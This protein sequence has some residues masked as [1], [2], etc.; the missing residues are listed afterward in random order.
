MIFLITL[1]WILSII[2]FLV[3]FYKADFNFKDTFIILKRWAFSFKEFVLKEKDK[4]VIEKTRERNIIETKD[5]EEEGDCKHPTGFPL[6]LCLSTE[7]NDDERRIRK[8]VLNKIKKEPVYF[9]DRNM[10][11]SITKKLVVPLETLIFFNKELNPLVNEHGEIILSTREE[12][13]VENI[14]S[15]IME[16]R[17]SNEIIYQTDSEIVNAISELI[18]ISKET[19]ATISE[20]GEKFKEKLI[21]KKEEQNS[22]PEEYYPSKEEEPKDNTKQEVQDKPKPQQEAQVKPKPKSED[23]LDL[24]ELEDLLDEEELSVPEMEIPDLSDMIE[25]K[26]EKDLK[27]EDDSQNIKSFLSKRKWEYIEGASIN[28]RDMN[29]TTVNIL[30][31]TGLSAFVNNIAKQKPLIFNENKV[32]VFVDIHIIYVAFSQLFGIDYKTV[33]AKL[34]KMPKNIQNKFH[35]GIEDSIEKYLS[36]IVSGKKGVIQSFFKEDGDCFRA[37]GIWVTFDLFRECFSD[38]ELDFFRSFPYN[39]TIKTSQKMSDCS[40]LVQDISDTEI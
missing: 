8:T 1:V 2:T 10:D 28:W 16:L 14:K 4:V 15:V 9:E 40:P 37:T 39:N 23:K 12:E 6:D 18:K 26:K 11:G 13:I 17:D 5:E 38:D 32:A 7:L 33:I 30:S 29:A 25:V 20:I 27:D 31:G 36:D 24:D 34:K 22:G 3:A 21:S 19:G 35:T